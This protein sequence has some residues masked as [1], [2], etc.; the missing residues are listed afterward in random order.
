[1]NTIASTDLLLH[2]IPVDVQ[3]LATAV[4][5]QYGFTLSDLM[6][7][8]LNQFLRDGQKPFYPCGT[9]VEEEK[10]SP[11]LQPAKT[12]RDKSVDELTV[13]D[14]K[15][16]LRAA[17]RGE[18]PPPRPSWKSLAQYLPADPDFLKER[19]EL[20]DFERVDKLFEGWEG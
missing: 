10:A 4:A 11:P 18:P 6:R 16:M 15:E 5:K 20:F 8:L 9:S 19:P 2:D 7:R 12:F 17:H 14:C 3:K 13:E 1:M